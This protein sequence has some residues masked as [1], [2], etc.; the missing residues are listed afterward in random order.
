M[1]E[2]VKHF[3][4]AW[5]HSVSLKPG[6]RTNHPSLFPTTTAERIR[7]FINEHHRQGLTCTS[8]HIQ[9][10]LDS[11]FQ[12]TVHQRSIQRHLL[13]LGFGYTRIKNQTPSIREMPSMRQQRHTYLYEIDSLRQE[14]YTIVY[15]DESF[16]H[17]YHGHHSSW[18]RTSDV[19]EKPAGFGRRWCFI[20]AYSADG[21]LP[22][23]F[24]I[25]EAKKTTDDYHGSFN[26]EVFYNWFL[27]QPEAQFTKEILHCYGSRN[28]S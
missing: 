24:L 10:M 19:F 4:L 14:G 18:F 1:V 7:E 12:I 3:K 17:H 8:K 13:D 23:S 28:L 20:H 16:I 6:N 11:K 25:F 5:Y 27:E 15:L 2:I 21:F 9:E 22:N 26:F